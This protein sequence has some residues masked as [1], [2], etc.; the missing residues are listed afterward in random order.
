MNKKSRHFIRALSRA[1]LAA[2]IVSLAGGP[3][4]AAAVVPGP[5]CTMPCCE[6]YAHDRVSPGTDISL[7]ART[8][9]CCPLSAAAPCDLN[10]APVPT[11]TVAV[12]GN[13]TMV[14]LPDGLHSGGQRQSVDARR[15]LTRRFF[16]A[17][18]FPSAFPPLF[19][20]QNALLY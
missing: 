17:A 1:L 3:A 2:A 8:P 16:K 12:L 13:A 7:S 11:Q 20:T 9:D 15:P 5:K 19:L 14:F 18:V 10:Q 4:L 6:P